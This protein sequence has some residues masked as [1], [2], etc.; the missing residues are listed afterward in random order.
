MIAYSEGVASL[1]YIA[2]CKAFMGGRD[3]RRTYGRTAYGG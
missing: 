2:F 3:F 1:Q